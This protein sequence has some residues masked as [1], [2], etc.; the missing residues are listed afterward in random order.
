MP[1]TVKIRDPWESFRY[2]RWSWAQFRRYGRRLADL[3]YPDLSPVAARWVET[4]RRDGIVRLEGSP[5]TLDESTRF[6]ELPRQQD[7]P[8]SYRATGVKVLRELSFRQASLVSVLLNPDLH[9]CLWH[10][11]GRPYFVRNHP[12]YQEIEVRPEDVPEEER[13][14]R[15]HVDGLGQLSVMVLLSPTRESDPHMQ[16]A[17]GT[18]RR[19]VWRYGLVLSPE[20]AERMALSARKLACVGPAGTAYLF[21]A[22]GVHR[23]LVKPG[24]RKMLHLNFTTGLNLKPMVESFADWPELDLA[25]AHVRSAFQL[26]P[27]LR[28]GSGLA[29]LASDLAHE[30]PVPLR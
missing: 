29:A 16:Y 4:L 7:V 19:A 21:D 15:F 30:N 23:R 24:K 2:L 25:P 12:V 3:T 8:E 5:W 14:N 6:D 20:Q 1:S 17:L 11:L 27:P 18:H 22:F 9:A 28:A 26:P 13:G 10:Y